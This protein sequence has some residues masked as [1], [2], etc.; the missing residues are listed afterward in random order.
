[1]GS[2]PVIIALGATFAVL[3]TTL[4]LLLTVLAPQP[5]QPPST[6]VA[7]IGGPFRM[8]DEDGNPVTEAV[9]AGKPSV[10]FFGFTSCPEVCPTTLA[11]MS[12]LIERMGEQARSLNFVFVSVDA[13]R[14][15][16]ERVRSYL[17]A[18]DPQ[19]MGLTGDEEQVAAITKAYR[20][21]YR[22]VPLENGDY[23]VDHTASVYLMDA[24]GAFFGTIDYHEAADTAVQK[25]ER[26]AETQT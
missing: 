7:D 18:F 26:L 13:G 3:A 16:P 24:Q 8:V 23:T 4:V 19:I 21:F 25:L 12:G 2:K 20:V 6:G 17:S 1:M 9:L 22:K 15:T 14:D 5:A 11:D 10:V